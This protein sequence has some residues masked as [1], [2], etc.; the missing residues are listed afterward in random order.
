MNGGVREGLPMRL[1]VWIWMIIW[2]GGRSVIIIRS[3]FLLKTWGV[4]PGDSSVSEEISSRI[5]GVILYNGF[6][7]Q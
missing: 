5:T 1:L 3:F 2:R 7:F 4:V 6:S